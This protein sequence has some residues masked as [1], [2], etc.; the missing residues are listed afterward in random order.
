MKP[1][2]LAGIGAWS[3][4]AQ[5]GAEPPPIIQVVRK[6]GTSVPPA[7]GYGSAGAAVNVVGMTSIT[8]LPETWLLEAHGS[9]SSIEALD[10]GL[11]SVA[12]K[13]TADPGDPLQ[14][15][16][17]APARTLVA[18]YRHYL[19]YR[20]EQAIRMFPRARYFHMTVY[21]IRTGSEADFS[22]LV[23]LRRLNLDS[24]NLDR[25]DIAYQV[26]SGAPSGTYV[27]LAPLASLRTMDDAVASLPFYAESLSRAEARTAAKVSAQAEISREHLLF[28]VEPRISYVSDDF[29]E[30]DPEFW[31]GKP[32]GR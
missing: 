20:P 19:S 3:A 16:V 26:V 9:F 6:V 23:K 5:P 30:A 10:K 2:L 24:V 25:P 15:D 27:F 18:L 4:A 17:L 29:A 8:G 28:R 32:R 21:R 12:P 13:L 22:E 14:D 1:I 11:N 31:R 7:R